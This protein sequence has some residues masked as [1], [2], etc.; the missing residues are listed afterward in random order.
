[1]YTNEYSG[2]YIDF[3][4]YWLVLKRRWLPATATCLSAIALSFCF[5]MSKQEELYQA[6][7]QIL[8]EK[9]NKSTQFTG[10]QN[11]SS[12][13]E[14]V[15]KDGDPLATQAEILQSRPILERVILEL[16]LRSENGELLN[17]GAV[18][19]NL[20]AEPL[21][22]TD[23]IEVSYE[24]PEPVS[25]SAIA[26]KV[27][28]I[29]MEDDTASNRAEAIAARQF[30][31]EQLPQLEQNVNQA[32]EELRDFKNQNQLA[33]LPEETSEL[34]S[35]NSQLEN[36]IEEV[37][38]ELES[39]NARY[40]L[41][42]GRLGLT[43]EQ[44]AAMNALNESVAVRQTFEKL[45]EV[46]LNIASERNRFSESAPQMIN[47]REQ[48]RELQSLLDQ[49]IA[50]NLSKEQQ[51]AISQIK[52]FNLGQENQQQIPEF[53]S[54]GLER[55]GLLEKL[56]SL[57]DNLRTNQQR[58]ANLP[59]LEKQQRELSRRLEAAQSTYQ[60]LLGKLQE[61]QVIEN[62]NIGN[63]RVI[64]SAIVPTDPIPSKTKLIVAAGGVAGVLLG[65][66]VAFLLDLRDNKV[67]NSKEVEDIFARSVQGVIPNLK[68][69]EPNQRLTRSTVGN[70]PQPAATNSS[71]RLLREACQNI[72]INLKLLDKEA[73][74]KV[75]AVTST[76]PQEGKSS[77]SANLAL[78]KA[79]SGQ[80]ILLVDGD[81]RV[82]TQH[83]IWQ[84]PN[85]IGLTNVLYEEIEWRSAIQKVM[86]NLD[87]L[88]SGPIPESPPRLLYSEPMKALVVSLASHYDQ[89][90]FDTPPLMGIADTKIL[91]NLVDG[92]L[93]VVR[94]G[95]APYH[96][97]VEAKKFLDTSDLK[98][99]GIVVNGVD[100]SK[101]HG[102]SSYYYQN[103]KYLE[104]G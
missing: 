23:I 50:Q 65:I 81:L 16:D 38:A 5:A 9:S 78:A 68:K 41:L 92:F 101:E 8:I 28:E 40:N 56:A 27:I 46:K 51:A 15:T 98:L 74:Y 31:S 32:E 14:N 55:E 77:V 44:A 49:Q 20:K 66:G 104:A 26:N 30:M 34:I 18:S 39:I 42:S 90:I 71:M 93:F 84:M 35:K 64:E 100:R 60:T 4:K 1:M 95:V 89:I 80:R 58:L 11:N 47:W 25:A 62:Q 85:E 13:I 37:T 7:A 54:L 91:G 82:P 22:G 99:L 48:E 59:G 6:K 43:Q 103:K 21:L 52:I 87:I 97:V 94:V 63:V 70:L 88:T 83:H 24:D 69:I 76:T 102:H 61:T 29:Y 12:E 36:E 45:H 3:Q 75:I 2:E 19:G 96:S 72:H 86:P 57:K 17:Y 73:A 67:K 53:I 79:Q 33:N 10:I